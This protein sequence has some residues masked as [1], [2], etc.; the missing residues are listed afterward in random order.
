MTHSYYIVES[1]SSNAFTTFTRRDGEQVRVSLTAYRIGPFP[2]VASAA[3]YLTKNG[4][5]H[6]SYNIETY[7]EPPA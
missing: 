4:I 6:A 3:D 2:S 5:L 7:V 1:T